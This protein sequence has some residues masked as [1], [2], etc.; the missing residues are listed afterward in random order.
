MC[1]LLELIALPIAC[2]LDISRADRVILILS[3]VF[4]LFTEVINTAT[5]AVVDPVGI[6]IYPLSDFKD[7]LCCNFSTS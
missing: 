5:E 3:V 6:E 2:L 1:L 7:I 4:I